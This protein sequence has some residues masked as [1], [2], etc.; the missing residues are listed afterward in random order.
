MGLVQP[1]Y[2]TEN[3]LTPLLALS[4][5]FTYLSYPKAVSDSMQKDNHTQKQKGGR[6]ERSTE[7]KHHGHRHVCLSW[8]KW[9]ENKNTYRQVE[10]VVRKKN[11]YFYCAVDIGLP[12]RLQTND[13]WQ[14]QEIV[15]KD[16][17]PNL[18]IN[19]SFLGEVRNEW[20]LEVGKVGEASKSEASVWE[21]ECL[22]PCSALAAHRVFP[23]DN[24]SWCQRGQST[25]SGTPSWSGK[26]SSSCRPNRPEGN[27]LQVGILRSSPAPNRYILT[28]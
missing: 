24:Q 1:G 9:K 3:V 19:H 26:L 15:C 21:E 10:C 27:T 18:D 5:T 6:N 7:R 17:I 11:V 12:R 25:D 2:I 23:H 16:C 28:Q 13:L 22:L 8:E 14:K 20:R 4:W